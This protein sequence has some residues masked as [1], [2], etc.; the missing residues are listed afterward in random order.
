MLQKVLQ[1][2]QIL[3]GP[4]LIHR[5]GEDMNDRQLSKFLS[6]AGSHKRKFM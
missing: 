4:K 5:S 6:V 1:F 3:S 2:S